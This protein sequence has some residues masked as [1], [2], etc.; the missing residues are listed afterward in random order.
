[1]ITS[2]N[3][4]QI[5]LVA[6]LQAKAKARREYN[7][8]VAE[9][10]RMVLEAPENRVR[11]VYVS[12]TY[13]KTHQDVLY[14]LNVPWDTVS[15]KLFAQMSETKTPQGILAIVECLAYRL[16]DLLKIRHPLL[17]VL[18]NIQDPGNL[19]TMIRTAEGAGAAGV[20]MSPDTVD[21]YNPK[22][23]RSTMGS[24]YR[25]PFLYADY[26]EELLK[27]LKKA[28]VTLYAAHL[29]GS[30]EYTDVHYSDRTALLIGNEGNG[31]TKKT[32]ELSDQCV[33]IPMS[34]KVESLNASIAA[35]ILLFEVKRQK[36]LKN[37]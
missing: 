13:A 12:E 3:N 7:V 9:G 25:V 37:Y 34:G 28:E 24:L 22:V 23:I 8:F 16:E 26:F 5:R 17:L 33:K 2:T 31:L 4:A 21:I 1:M 32:V 30:R 20:I 11:A 36:T 35:S 27:Q 6:A 19:G 14:K 15:D 29:D 10:E 18:E